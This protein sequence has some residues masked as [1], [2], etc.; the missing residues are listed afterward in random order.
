MIRKKEGTAPTKAPSQKE[1]TSKP[2][3]SVAVSNTGVQYREILDRAF[4]RFSIIEAR[5]WQQIVATDDIGIT[6]AWIEA[7]YQ[8]RVI[9]ANRAKLPGDAR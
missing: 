9:A 6:R 4:E 5:L 2:A 1:G 7:A 3:K 8:L